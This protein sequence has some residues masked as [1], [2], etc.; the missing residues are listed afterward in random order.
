M[1]FEV[2]GKLYK[3]FDT[4]QVTDS[5]Q[6]REFVVEMEDG[7]YPQIV[8]FQL[9]QANCEKLDRYNEGDEVK[10]T[11]NLRGR[12]YNKDGKTMY[13]TNLDAWR[14]DSAGQAQA[15]T[16]QPAVDS[17][18]TAT[19]APAASTEMDDLPF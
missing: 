9:T 6:K 18:P 8:K 2:T 16:T 15:Q 14:I 5:F 10:V 17:F 19:D 3:K 7:A 12:E 13:F 1:A 4:Q 11:F